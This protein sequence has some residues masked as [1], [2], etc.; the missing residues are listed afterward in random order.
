MPIEKID[1]LYG[2]SEN[3]IGDFFYFVEVG[4]FPLFDTNVH[5]PVLSNRNLHASF[6]RVENQD[7]RSVA[8]RKGVGLQAARSDHSVN[9]PRI[10]ERRRVWRYPFS[11]PP[12]IRQR[13]QFLEFS[14]QWIGA[15]I[16]L[17][18]G[19]LRICRN[20]FHD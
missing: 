1:F 3:S 8:T 11:K 10:V 7:Q 13:S 12:S 19:G 18:G 16:S 2:I 15:K 17:E 5:L 6:I 4:P 20:V 9:F 14:Q